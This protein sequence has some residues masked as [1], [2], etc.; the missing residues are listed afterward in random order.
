MIDSLRI[1]AYIS[2]LSGSPL[3]DSWVNIFSFVVLTIKGGIYMDVFAM[4][5][6]KMITRAFAMAYHTTL[7]S[8]EF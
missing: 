7:L 5:L 1:K 4:E 6:I 8:H 3:F 2:E